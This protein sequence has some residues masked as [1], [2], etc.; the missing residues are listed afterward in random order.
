MELKTP[1][2]LQEA[3]TY[4]ADPEQAFISAV[5]LRWPDGKI[6]CP[7]C[8]GEKH[9]FVK[10]RLLWFCKGCK[11]Q[12]TVKVGT[13]MEDS[14][15]GLDKW[16]TAVWMIVNCKNGISSWEI[17]R[18]LGITQKSAWFLLQRI[19]E[20]LSGK[21]FTVKTKLGGGHEG[22]EVEVDETYI[23]GK[24]K[25][26]HKAHRIRSLTQGVH[27]GKTA[28]QG[29][30]DRDLRQVRAEV[31]PNVTRETLQSAVLK[32]IKYGTS[33]FTDD[34]VAYD[35]LKY[36]F[37]HDV[38]NH[39]KEY[40]RGRVHTNGLENFWSLL[41]R[42][43]RGTY[44]AVEPFHLD[45]YLDEQ[46]FRYNHRGSKEHPVNDSKRFAIAMSQ[47]GGKRLTYAQLTGKGTD[48]VC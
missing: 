7:R 9:S 16:M 21:G 46:V 30:L 48:S 17:H 29:F 26:M 45:R 42:N 37:V 14:P 3:I 18:A 12:F 31:V 8:S 22:S 32:N 35:M 2:T 4:F 40:V 41:K 39:A 15:I 1:K 47:I 36:K 43:L 33:V 34:A 44:V 28:V 27:V 10:T 6:R 24:S 19:R 38:V 20:A 23:G 13:I 5:N 25:N 11:R